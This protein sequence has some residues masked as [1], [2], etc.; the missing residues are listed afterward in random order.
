MQSVALG[1]QANLVAERGFTVEAQV[2]EVLPDLLAVTQ[3]AIVPIAELTKKLS[4]Q[5]GPEY[6]RPITNRWV[7]NV[8][9]K[10]LGL[11]TYKSHDTYVIV[12]TRGWVFSMRRRLR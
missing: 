7:G 11:K 9:R 4:E 6:E 10:R 1:A 3:R 8:V 2:L 5:Y 12:R